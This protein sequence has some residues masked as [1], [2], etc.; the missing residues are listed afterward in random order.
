MYLIQLGVGL[1]DLKRYNFDH[2]FDGTIDSVCSA[3]DGIEDATHFLL[4]CKLYTH[5]RIE[6]LNSVCRLTGTNVTDLDQQALVKLLLFGN[7]EKL[8]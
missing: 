5:I 2:N 6:L 7:V 1:N 4:S 8:F 3:N